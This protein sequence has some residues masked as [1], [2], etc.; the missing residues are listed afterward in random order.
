MGSPARRDSTGDVSLLVYV[1]I[2]TACLLAFLSFGVRSSFGVFLEPILETRG[3]DRETF[4]LALAI[5][6]LMWG[7][8]Q[9]FAGILADS[10]GYGRVLIGGAALYIIG[11]VSMAY[12]ETPLVFHLCG[13]VVAGI[14]M[15]GASWSI[16]VG[17]V[18]RLAPAHLHGWATGMAV[19]ACSLGQLAIVTLSQAFI[20]AYG[21]QSALLILAGIIALIVP[22][23]ALLA[24]GRS[25]AAAKPRSSLSETLRQAARSRSF[26]LI[27]TGF[28]ICGFHAGFGFT[29]IPAYFTSIGMSPE[30]GAWALGA[31]GLT[32]LFSSYAVGVLG[33]RH[34]KRAI[35]I[36][37]YALRSIAMAALVLFP[38]SEGVALLLC[39][40]LGIFWMSS[41][42]PTSGLLGQ[43][44][45]SYY[46]GTL[47]GLVSF[48]HQ[49]GAFLGA[50]LGGAIYD[51]TGS[52]DGAWWICIIL[53]IG[54]TL[55]ILPV[56]ER[57]ARTAPQPV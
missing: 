37:V 41:I 5:Q 44:F 1:C 13:G 9:P 33:Q 10:R 26:W 45:G 30:T 21:W 3:W 36:V 54:A 22:C 51:R 49:V 18:M 34:S 55:L 47:L 28:M 42:P 39:A 6:N 43:I 40:A 38:V 14:G 46:T 12:A 56:D 15:A 25:R 17:A 57:A 19:A 52:Y 23:A 35:L 11:T 24:G 4:G 27:F 2:L 50:W 48:G 7:A 31:I 20:A 8:A 29:H 53:S 32:N 16:A